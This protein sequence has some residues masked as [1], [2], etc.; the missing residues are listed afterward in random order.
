MSRNF[1]LDGKGTQD[2]DAFDIPNVSHVEHQ[3]EFNWLSQRIA[4]LVLRYSNRETQRITTRTLLK[5][6]EMLLSFLLS[7]SN[8]RLI[9]V[10]TEISSLSSVPAQFVFLGY[11]QG[12]KNAFSGTEIK[13]L[14][15]AKLKN[16]EIQKVIQESHKEESLLVIHVRKGDYADQKNLKFGVLDRDYYENAINFVL[17]KSSFTEVEI[18]SDDVGHARELLANLLPDQANWIESLYQSTAATF[19]S[20]RHGSAYILA[21]SSFGWWAARLCLKESPIV[22]YPEPWFKDKY[23][24]LESP[25]NWHSISSFKVTN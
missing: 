8:S 5:M 15:S 13:C 10:R 16:L 14:Q 3:V 1:R 20:M 11:F 9:L 24:A 23:S 18:Y 7:T 2:M 17:Q 25:Q 21:N 6:S 22:V 4:N 19:E 12:Q